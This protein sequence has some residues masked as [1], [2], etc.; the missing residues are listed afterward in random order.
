M[1]GVPWFTKDLEPWTVVTGVPA[2][3]VAV[4]RGLNGHEVMGM[5]EPADVERIA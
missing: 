2:Q 4:R 1:P 5:Q 3:P